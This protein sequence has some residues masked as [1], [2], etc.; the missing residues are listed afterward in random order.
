V[1]R[2]N[3]VHAFGCNSAGSE[4]IWMKFGVVRVYSLEMALADFGHTV[5]GSERW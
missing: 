2:F 1:V 3:D 5:H 4:R